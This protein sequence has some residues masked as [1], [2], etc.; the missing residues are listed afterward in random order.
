MIV[1]ELTFIKQISLKQ[2]QHSNCAKASTNG[3]KILQQKRFQ[4]QV[5]CNFYFH[6]SNINFFL[7][8]FFITTVSSIVSD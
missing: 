3:A 7:N 1:T 6:K 4:F 8:T 2:R 5:V